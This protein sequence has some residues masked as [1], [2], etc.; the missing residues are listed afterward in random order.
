MFSNE[1]ISTSSAC[2]HFCAYGPWFPPPQTMR[3]RLGAATCQLGQQSAQTERPQVAA[4]PDR[5]QQ[6]PPPAFMRANAPNDPRSTAAVTVNALVH[7]V[8]NDGEGAERCH[9][10]ATEGGGVCVCVCSGACACACARSGASVRGSLRRKK[11]EG[12]EV[13]AR[14]SGSDSLRRASLTGGQRA[15]VRGLRQLTGCRRA[16]RIAQSR[17]RRPAAGSRQQC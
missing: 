17:P 14:S 9:T 16:A 15:R 7:K 5:G 6:L 2:R 11:R 12:G 8:Q 1:S 13:A 3:D 4:H 10:D